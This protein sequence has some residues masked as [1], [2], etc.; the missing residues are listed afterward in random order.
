MSWC[1]CFARCSKLFF[2]SPPYKDE[3]GSTWL[4][5]YGF[6]GLTVPD[7]IGYPGASYFG[8]I[9]IEHRPCLT[10]QG[11][12]AH[13]E[14]SDTEIADD[15]LKWLENNRTSQPFFMT[16]HSFLSA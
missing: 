12:G 7:P 9:E 11:V 15:A 13:G 14:V 5:D 2:F 3:G 6:H 10:G 8:A 16:V 1:D 4:N